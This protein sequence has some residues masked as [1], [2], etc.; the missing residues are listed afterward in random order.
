MDPLTE[1]LNI[2]RQLA[3]RTRELLEIV[4]SGTGA[5]GTFSPREFIK[6]LGSFLVVSEERILVTRALMLLVRLRVL[7]PRILTGAIEFATASSGE[8][9]IVRLCAC[10]H[11]LKTN[12]NPA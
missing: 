8:A 4:R 11:A 3:P 1:Y 6:L 12:E 9:G 10:C 7:T 5:V 2:L